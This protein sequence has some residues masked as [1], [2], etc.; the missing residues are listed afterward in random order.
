MDLI[1]VLLY[2]FCARLTWQDIT[3][4]LTAQCGLDIPEGPQD[5]I[6]GPQGQN[7]LM[8]ILKYVS[9]FHSYSLMSI[10]GIFQKLHEV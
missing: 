7:Y 3:S 1:S 8:I 2:D 5:I 9:F 6:Q 10:D 4:R